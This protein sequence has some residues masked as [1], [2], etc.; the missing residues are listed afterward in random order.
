VTSTNPIGKCLN[1]TRVCDDY[2]DCIDK[3]DEPEGLCNY[4]TTTTKPVSTTTK[5]PE[6]LNLIKIF[7]A[8]ILRII[9]T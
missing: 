5:L 6:G 7:F 8:A 4:T 9:Y 2:P 3:S 1:R